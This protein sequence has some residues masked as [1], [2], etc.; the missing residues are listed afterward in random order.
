LL[1]FAL[2]RILRAA[3]QISAHQPQMIVELLNEQAGPRSAGA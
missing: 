2:A 3:R 1:D